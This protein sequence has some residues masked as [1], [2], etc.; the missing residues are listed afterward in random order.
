ME[1]AVPLSG[2]AHPMRRRAA[3]VAAA[4]ALLSVSGMPSGLA[5]EPAPTGPTATD[6]A[7]RISLS[8]TV[9]GSHVSTNM[10]SISS[11]PKSLRVEVQGTNV[12]N[13]DYFVAATY[14]GR[15][16]SEFSLGGTITVVNDAPSSRTVTVTEAMPGTACTVTD[17]VERTIAAA[18]S[19]SFPFTCTPDD[20]FQPKDS[21]TSTASV[22]W[23]EDGT[24][25]QLS[26]GAEEVGWDGRY[27][28]NT[29]DIFDIDGNELSV[30]GSLM[31]SPAN[32]LQLITPGS[33]TLDGSI[34]RFTYRAQLDGTP[35]QCRT[36]TT[37]AV[38]AG[39]DGQHIA[40]D[41]ASVEVC[42]SAGFPGLPH[43][44]N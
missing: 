39:D 40:S 9:T 7:G 13:V 6:V 3:L 32:A 19:T 27:V 31:V 42:A 33:G 12:A 2:A 34:W 43:A 1:P 11:A 21:D 24:L 4:T 25:H 8:T 26:T 17:G 37:E 14:G 10:W 23:T 30:L 36:Y 18:G 22:T 38:V 5:E 15:T 28:D 29:V 35:G 41:P 16:L 20:G 44:G